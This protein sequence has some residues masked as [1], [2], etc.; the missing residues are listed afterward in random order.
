MKKTYSKPEIMF[1]DFTMSES[2]AIGCEKIA[3]QTLYACQYDYGKGSKKKNIFAETYGCTYTA[4]VRWDEELQDF[5]DDRHDSLCYHVPF[6][7]NNL[8]TSY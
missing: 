5:I 3:N 7:T 1:E 4:T 6:E 2:I 8:F